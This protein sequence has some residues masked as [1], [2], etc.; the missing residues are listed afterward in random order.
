MAQSI[1][2]YYNL[3]SASYSLTVYDDVV[4]FNCSTGSFTA[5][6]PSAASVPVSKR[7]EIRRAADATPANTLT[8]NTTSSQTIDGRASGSIILSPSDYLIVVSD[9]SNWQVVT[10]QETVSATYNAYTNTGALSS[11]TG[12]LIGW[13]TKEIDTHSGMSAGTYT[14]RVAG[15]Y[16]ITA[17]ISTTSSSSGGEAEH[18]LQ[19]NG[20]TLRR[21]VVPSAPTPAHEVTTVVFFV[22]RFVVGDTINSNA[23][24]GFGLSSYNASATDNYVHIV[25][26]GN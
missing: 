5:T 23:R 4:Q 26:V 17:S 7:F 15:L 19:K 25:K 2:P 20:S 22:G 1:L 6:L 9:G 11:S 8:V 21:A 16:A 13:N 24:D 10:L 18:S 14:V 12:N 3:Q